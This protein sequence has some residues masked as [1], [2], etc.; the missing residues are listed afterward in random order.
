MVFFNALTKTRTPLGPS[1]E[2]RSPSWVYPV[3]SLDHIL[4]FTT[5]NWL[6]RTKEQR[7]IT[8]NRLDAALSLV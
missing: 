4:G 3:K 6:K 2:S 8:T 7:L 5:F 1:R